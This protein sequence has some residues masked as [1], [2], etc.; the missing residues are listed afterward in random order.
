MDA[1]FPLV[2]VFVFIRFLSLAEGENVS[3]R[4]LVNLHPGAGSMTH[5]ASQRR[6]CG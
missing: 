2:A 3:P 4:T 5:R 1:H 6:C